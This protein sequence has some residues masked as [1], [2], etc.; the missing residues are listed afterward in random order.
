MR[1]NATDISLGSLDLAA[2]GFVPMV[3]YT[4]FALGVDLIANRGKM[5]AAPEIVKI[6]G[7]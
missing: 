4:A 5:V 1:S 7:K 2:L 6:A 3:F